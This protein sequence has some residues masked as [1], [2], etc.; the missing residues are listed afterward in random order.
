VFASLLP[1]S[2]CT[3]TFPYTTLFR[4]DVSGSSSS[5]W[6]LC[7]PGTSHF[8]HEKFGVSRVADTTTRVFS[9][10]KDGQALFF[11]GLVPSRYSIIS[12]YIANDPYARHR[13]TELSEI[14]GYSL[15]EAY[16]EADIY[17]WEVYELGHSAVCLALADFA[18]EKLG[19]EPTVVVGQSFGSFVGALFSGVLS[20][21]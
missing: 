21:E 14:L 7:G 2:T 8:S 5:P 9:A 12:E 11:P 13:F 16:R 17:D 4:S 6:T 20:T 15:V 1:H 3:S 10:K 18:V 19:V